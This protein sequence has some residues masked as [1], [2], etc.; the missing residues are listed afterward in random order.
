MKIILDP[1]NDKIMNRI[2][3]IESVSETY[4]LI[5]TFK[6]SE[7]WEAF[8][9][10]GQCWS[11]DLRSAG[12]QKLSTSDSE[13][14]SKIIAEELAMILTLGDIE[15][16][17]RLKDLRGSWD[18]TTLIKSSQLL[19]Q[20]QRDKLNK[21]VILQNIGSGDAPT[22]KPWKS[23]VKKAPPRRFEFTKELLARV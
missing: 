23:Q 18:K 7:M 14:L 4:S 16:L 8:H 17:G 3:D 20:L 2:E 22:K 13:K 1:F 9:E 6:T 15:L 19:A 11:L 12:I 5:L 21:M 10:I